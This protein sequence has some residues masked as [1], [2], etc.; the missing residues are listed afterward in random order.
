MSS[1]AYFRKLV[2]EETKKLN[3]LCIKWGALSAE[4]EN[5]PETSKF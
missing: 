2:E 3:D 4:N 5:I 1:I